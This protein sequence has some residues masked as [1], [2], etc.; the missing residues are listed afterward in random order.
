MVLRHL[1]ANVVA[2][3]ALLLAMTSTSYA[4]VQLADGSVTTKKLAKNAVTS[5]KIKK[6]A[7]KS[8]DVKDGSL[9]S[10]DVKDHSIGGVD[11]A[12]GVVPGKAAVFTD[13]VLSTDPTS[14]PDGP[15]VLPF[16][17]TLP[18]A[19][20]VEVRWFSGA[21]H[22]SCSAGPGFVGAYVDGKPVPGTG[23]P[24][25]ASP[26]SGPAELLGTVPLAAGPHTASLGFDCPSGNWT[27]SGAQ[28]SGWEV[29]LLSD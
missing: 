7:V 27:S 21:E 14:T 23:Q 18:R 25:Y 17:F 6:A 13:V 15:N 4:A 10:N 5:S 11:L 26:D 9:A 24:S 28:W 22:I 29:S 2:Y 20:T 19:G 12:A 16:S 1:R 3:L 8:S